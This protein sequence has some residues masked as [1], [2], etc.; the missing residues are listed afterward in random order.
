MTT[1]ADVRFARIVELSG[2]TLCVVLAGTMLQARDADN[3]E[4]W[5]R[6][7]L[8]VSLVLAVAD[9]DGR[10][11]PSLLVRADPRTLLV[12][13]ARS[14]STDWTWTAPVGSFISDHG[15]WLLAPSEGGL[16]LVVFPTYC[17]EGWA[18]DFAGDRQSPRERWHV[19]PGAWDAGFGPSV[20]LGPLGLA[21]E[22][23]LLLSSRTGS[24]YRRGPDGTT[25]SAEL[26]L[27]RRRGMLYQ[28][29][30]DP[31]S[32]ALVSETAFV[33]EPRRYRAARPYGLLTAAPLRPGGLAEVV[34]VSCQVEEYLAVTRRTRSGGL[35]RRWGH[36][37]EKDWPVDERELRPQPSSLTDVDGDG[38]PELVVGLW[39]DDRWR[40]LVL[41]PETAF[42]EPKHVFEDRYFWGCIPTG[43]DA[44]PVLV[45]SEERA[46]RPAG[47]TTLE[48]VDP[49]RAAPVAR[50]AAA[51][52]LASADEP[53]PAATAFM[54]QR[55]S[56][57]AVSAGKGRQGVLVRRL[58]DTGDAGTW[59]WGVDRDERPFLL[60]LGGA[61]IGRVDRDG[62]GGLLLSNGRGQI[63]RLDSALRPIGKPLTPVGR[64]ATPLVRD[65]PTGPELVIDRAGGQVVGGRPTGRGRLDSGWEIAGR[66]PALIRHSAGAEIVAVAGE[67][68][69]GPTLVVH[70]A[71]PPGSTPGSVIRLRAPLDHAPTP[72]PGD[73]LVLT[74]R[75]GTH[76]LATE[77]RRLDGT[78]VWAAEVGAYLHPPAV[79]D[80]PNHQPVV[81]FDDHGKLH[82]YATNGSLLGV[83]DWTAAYTLPIVGRLGPSGSWAILRA[84]GIHGVELLDA[85]GRRRWRREA[86]LWHF[87]AGRGAVGIP[88]EDGRAAVAL[89]ARDGTLECLD[90]ATGETRW[91][92][93]LGVP[94]DA[95]VVAADVD[96]DGLDEFLVGLPN[97]RLV[98]VGEGSSGVAERWSVQ[99]GAAVANPIV[100]DVDGDG[101]AEVIVATADGGVH[102]LGWP[103][104]VRPRR[105]DRPRP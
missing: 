41:D 27:G 77:V 26:V 81:V 93:Q 14:G 59:A 44:A 61:G 98:A 91:L 84:S 43:S 40:T 102:I 11:E 12:V 71:S 18:F 104:A 96:G 63:R 3:R 2:R 57:M 79:A 80:G 60:R 92:H 7:D 67:D 83:T 78:L 16:M 66:L 6:S 9:L 101:V 90:T 69:E 8:D 15:G 68:R 37:I 55:H 39:S 58:S 48:L 75:T 38:R 87:R 103:C 74:L 1:G 25:T 97:G 33:P 36:H 65:T 76:T 21:G 86:P 47:R 31:A 53:L 62:Y 95:S 82:R 28:A 100:A 35:A 51:T 5:R 4:A 52:V 45:L 50:L 30:L 22:P 23:Q 56:A 64:L 32:G 13:D 85:H 105:T 20:I 42:D 70:R 10:G 88:G 89:P 94:L 46:R 49:R 29:I 24:A 99:L 72:V 19:G 34:L 54:A 17:L 73:E